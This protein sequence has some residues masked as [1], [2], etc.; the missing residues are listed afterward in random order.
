MDNIY[1][2][3]LK[4]RDEQAFERLVL[5][6]QDAVVRYL[7]RMLGNREDALE[8]AQEVFIAAFRFIDKFRGD[9]SIKNWLFK[10]AHNLCKNHFRYRDR[11]RHRQTS[12]LDDTFERSGMNP[13]GSSSE[14]PEEVAEGK[15]LQAIMNQGVMEL[16]IDFREVLILRDM[17]LL[18]YDEIG[19]LT[20]LPAGTVKSRIHRAR[21]Q[22]IE[23]TRKKTREAK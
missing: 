5:E 20:N 3:Q 6:N 8:L 12:S 4:R 22:L 17:E 21:L 19:K 23:Y 10:I 7:S 15:E 14:S 11:R 2:K 9:C 1:L 13:V 18:S 16:S